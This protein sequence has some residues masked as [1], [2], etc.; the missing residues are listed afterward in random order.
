MVRNPEIHVNRW[1][2]GMLELDV[3][4]SAGEPIVKYLLNNTVFVVTVGRRKIEPFPY[5]DKGREH[6][7]RHSLT[8]RRH[9]S[10]PLHFMP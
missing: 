5:A 1:F 2:R 3:F 10:A 9:F 6:E 8:F 4:V 7:L